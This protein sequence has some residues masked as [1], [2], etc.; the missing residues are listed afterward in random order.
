MI[1]RKTQLFDACEPHVKFGAIAFY[2]GTDVIL[3][4]VTLFLFVKRLWVML[5]HKS[6]VQQN[7]SLV[8]RFCFS[9]CECVCVCVSVCVS[10]CVC[11]YIAKYRKK[12]IYKNKKYKN[13][14][15]GIKKNY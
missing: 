11:W 1:Y 15:T 10:V 2:G 6:R 9:L 8:Y 13:K 14:Q 12:K 5:N 3:S 7:P 4:F